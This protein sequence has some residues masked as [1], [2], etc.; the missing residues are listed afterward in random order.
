MLTA[1]RYMW[2]VLRRVVYGEGGAS[3]QLAGEHWRGIM[4]SC[5]SFTPG[6]WQL[7][8]PYWATAAAKEM[9]N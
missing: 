6:G 2:S 5:E 9:N 3:V 4:G 7:T 8:S 1:L